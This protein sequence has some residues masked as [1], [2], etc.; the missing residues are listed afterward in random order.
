LRAR[1]DAVPPEG[2]DR[3]SLAKFYYTAV[4][5]GCCSAIPRSS[6]RRAQRPGWARAPMRTAQVELPARQQLGQ[7]RG[8]ARCSYAMKQAGNLSSPPL[9]T[10][11]PVRR[12]DRVLRPDPSSLRR[13]AQTIKVGQRPGGAELSKP[14]VGGAAAR[15]D[16]LAMHSRAP[17]RHQIRGA[18]GL[19]PG[20]ASRRSG[21]GRGG[22]PT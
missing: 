17:P 2:A 9:S 18:D 7:R 19:L 13:R 22:L 20:G 16:S 8:I 21:Q 5:H 15:A 1:A 10:H 14:C 11:P 4:R 12:G 6:G 3:A